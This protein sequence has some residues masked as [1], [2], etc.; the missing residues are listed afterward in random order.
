M[1]EKGSEP[2]LSNGVVGLSHV[3]DRVKDGAGTG[4][5]SDSSVVFFNW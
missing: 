2:E 3:S 4:T 5:V 1:R